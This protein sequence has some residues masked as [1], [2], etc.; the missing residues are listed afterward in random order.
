MIKLHGNCFQH[1]QINVLSICGSTGE[2]L[3]KYV[4]LYVYICVHL[5]SCKI[6]V[7]NENLNANFIYRTAMAHP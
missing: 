7:Q 5:Y 3:S 6:I 1:M 4:F 2:A